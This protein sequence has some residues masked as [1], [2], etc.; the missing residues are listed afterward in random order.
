MGEAAGFQQRKDVTYAKI[1][2]A[3]VL[4]MEWREAGV[5]A[6]GEVRNSKVLTILTS[7]GPCYRYGEKWMNLGHFLEDH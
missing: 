5:G 6:R 3:A 4:A 1:T 2:L 7:W